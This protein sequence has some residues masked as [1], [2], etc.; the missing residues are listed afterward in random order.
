M[1]LQSAMKMHGITEVDEMSKD[2][3]ISAAIKFRREMSEEHSLLAANRNVQANKLDDAGKE[4]LGAMLTSWHKL[5][6]N[7]LRNK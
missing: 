3:F 2:A 6:D 4:R 7:F 5:A 1:N